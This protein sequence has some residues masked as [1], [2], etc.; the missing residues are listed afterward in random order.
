MQNLPSCSRDTRACLQILGMFSTLQ[1]LQI[2][3]SWC[4]NATVATPNVFQ[5]V[6]YHL[7][8]PWHV[9]SLRTVTSPLYS[10]VGQ[11]LQ[12]SWV[13]LLFFLTDAGTHFLNT[14]I[15]P[16]RWLL[17]QTSY[18][19][20]QYAFPQAPSMHFACSTV[21]GNVVPGSKTTTS[22]DKISISSI[23]P[24]SLKALLS[25]STCVAHV[26]SGNENLQANTSSS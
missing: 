16:S 2:L 7:I 23:I 26:S 5:C 8:F 15:L 19:K 24:S 10:E 25:R 21:A 12:S 17:L 6:F 14:T 20:S 9:T 3:H 1:A 13:L 22:L 11:C 18:D 4:R